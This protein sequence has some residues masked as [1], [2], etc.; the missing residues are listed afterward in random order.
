MMSNKRISIVLISFLIAYNTYFTY[1]PKCSIWGEYLNTNYE[2]SPIFLNKMDK[3]K[4]NSDNTF[5]SE[6][7]GK[8]TYDIEYSLKGTLINFEP[9]YE[10]G[11]NLNTRISRT[12]MGVPQILIF[13]DLSH[14]YVKSNN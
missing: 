6:S 4:L 1:L 12:R 3:L 11:I 8:G 10:M 14:Y 7:F 2:N 9:T 13:K 5:E